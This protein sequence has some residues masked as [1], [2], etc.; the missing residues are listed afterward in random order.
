MHGLERALRCWD[1][2]GAAGLLLE[3]LEE[4]SSEIERGGRW[5]AQLAS[6]AACYALR[7]RITPATR[8]AP[9]DDAGRGHP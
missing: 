6:E 2:V 7:S 8:S 3:A 4:A 5:S 1:T 9:D